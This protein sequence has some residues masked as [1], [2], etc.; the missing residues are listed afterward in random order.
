MAGGWN[1]GDAQACRDELDVIRDGGSRTILALHLIDYSYIQWASSEYRAAHRSAVESRAIL[2]E[3]HEQNP[4]LSRQ[5]WASQVASSWSLMFLGEWGEALK[6]TEAAITMLARN[7]DDRR[8]QKSQLYRAWLHVHA[9]DFA[10]ALAIC[11]S[12][13][14]MVKEPLRTYPRRVGLIVA[15][16]AEV[17]IRQPDRALERLQAAAAE[18]DRQRIMLDWYWRMQLELSLTEV[19]L[20]KGDLA[21]ARQQAA[22]FLEVAQGTA[23]RTWQ[24]LAWEA[25]ARVA[26]AGLDVARAQACIGKALSAINEADLPLAA[27]RVNA[28][29]AE[30][31]ER[32]G[33]HGSAKH[34]RELSRITILKLANSLPA[35]EPLRHTF[36]SA[37]AVR[38]VFADARDGRPAVRVTRP[39]KVAM[40]VSG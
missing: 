24:A 39:S 16:T 14:A 19:W 9:M 10:G 34:H 15:G 36:L 4:Y 17:A 38:N 13:L 37:P 29:A 21:K 32:R 8:A 2:F 30:I 11:D 33:D 18:M 3:G 20:A 25:N 6:E 27:W 7:G 40:V 1:G 22:Q 28:T 31:S 35:E 26:M 23:E 12:V 5:Y